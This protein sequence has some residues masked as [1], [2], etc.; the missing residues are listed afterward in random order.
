MDDIVLK[1]DELKFWKGKADLI[2]VLADKDNELVLSRD[3]FPNFDDDDWN[4][5]RKFLHKEE[6]SYT[7]SK[8][9]GTFI[10]NIKGYTRRK[11]DAVLDFIMYGKKIGNIDRV[12][13]ARRIRPRMVLMNG[14]NGNN[15]NN[16]NRKNNNNNNSNNNYS[17][18]YKKRKYNTGV[19]VNNNNNN[20]YTRRKPYAKSKG[21]TKNRRR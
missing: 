16:N 10:Y 18:S 14:N 8:K 5:L 13:N 15:G 19:R 2:E 6:V 9:Y 3:L 20:N 12:L 21:K 1:G 4:F 7:K 11:A 17:T